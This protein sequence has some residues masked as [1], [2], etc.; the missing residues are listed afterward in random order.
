MDFV[1]VEGLV[2]SVRLCDCVVLREPVMLRVPQYLTNFG[3][4]WALPTVTLCGPRA[5]Q[6]GA[7]RL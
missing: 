4:N 1:S 5:S 6:R 3:I 7:L 2:V